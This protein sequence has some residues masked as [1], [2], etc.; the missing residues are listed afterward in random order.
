MFDMS[1]KALQNALHVCFGLSRSMVPRKRKQMSIHQKLQSAALTTLG[2]VAPVLFT[3]AT[4]M[5]QTNY[6]WDTTAPAG[7]VGG[8][9]TWS[10]GVVNWNDAV[11][12]ASANAAWSNG[13]A[14]NNIA[15]I[16]AGTGTITVS[17]TVQAARV[18]LT[19]AYTVT[20]GTIDFG[21]NAGVL[22]NTATVT[23]FASTLVGTGGQKRFQAE[24]ARRCRHFH[25]RQ[26]DPHLEPPCVGK[27]THNRVDDVC[28]DFHTRRGHRR[29]QYPKLYSAGRRCRPE[30]AEFVRRDWVKPRNYDPRR[31][32]FPLEHGRVE[33]RELHG[34][35]RHLQFLQQQRRHERHRRIARRGE[36]IE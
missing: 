27:F 14:G 35:Q 13:S 11:G 30:Y 20:G 33:P 6:Y 8:S 5:A 23:S 31:S 1:T 22:N 28:G 24:Y 21:S 32:L 29:D 18:N 12:T 36:S 17:G 25:P 9:G 2:L 26:R 15:N 19:Q 10:T 4:A 7:L 16:T 34:L 3:G